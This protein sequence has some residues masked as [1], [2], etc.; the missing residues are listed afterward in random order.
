VKKIEEI[1]RAH[2]T[3]IRQAA[4]QFAMMHPAVVSVVLGAVAPDEVKANVHDAS[5]AI[6]KGLWSDLKSAGLLD[7]AAP[8]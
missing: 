7:P 4:I 5:V 1:C 3:T 6:P 2:D 8:I